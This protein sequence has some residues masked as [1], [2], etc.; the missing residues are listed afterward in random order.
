M[1]I[2]SYTL[3]GDNYPRRFP[4]YNDAERLHIF[5]ESALQEMINAGV[6]TEERFQIIQELQKKGEDADDKYVIRYPWFSSYLAGGV[7]GLKGYLGT[8]NEINFDAVTNIVSAFKEGAN[9]I[10][11]KRMGREESELWFEK[12]DFS[13]VNILIIE[14]THG[15]SDYYKGVDIPVLLNSTPQ[16]T[17]AH[18]R[19]RNRDGKTDSSFTMKVL[20]L[21]QNML[22]EQACKA[23]IIV[24]KQGELIDYKS[25]QA[26]MRAAEEQI[27]VDEANK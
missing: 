26:L 14:W 23:K 1:G 18:R 24:T 25:Y 3:S 9:E 21:E 11:L 2:G 8:P 5:R 7:K 4:V 19:A 12:V 22:R 16:E 17:L 27:R 6:Y 10:W 20:E 13:E 15:N